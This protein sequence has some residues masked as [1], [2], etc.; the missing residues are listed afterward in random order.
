[1]PLEDYMLSGEDIDARVTGENW[2]WMAT[3]VRI[4]RF[5]K[6]DEN[7]PDED[8][9]D[10]SYSEVSSIE[11]SS[12]SKGGNKLIGIIAIILGFIIGLIGFQS[13]EGII[14][15]VGVLIIVF[16][17]MVLLLGQS[18]RES[19]MKL[20]GTTVLSEGSD[21]WTLQTEEVD[22]EEVATFM[23]AVRKRAS[24]AERR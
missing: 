16:G 21:K 1:M 13:D 20:H 23:K 7:N 22:T 5:R 14:G 6:T 11:L 9:Q 2:I 19:T 17:F 8:I 18:W 15:M 12:E 4:L 3:S 24:E 10:V